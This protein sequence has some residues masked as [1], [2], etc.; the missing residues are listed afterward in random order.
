MM[1]LWR[2]LCCK[3]LGIL[4][5]EYI[6]GIPG[7][8]K[9]FKSVFD[10]HSV[11]IAKTAKKWDEN[12]HFFTNISEFQFDKFPENVAFEFDF[13]VFYSNLSSLYV[14]Y[15]AKMGDIE[16]S[17]QAKIF[18][19]FNA[20]YV[21]DECHNFLDKE[22]KIL[23]WW[24]TYH[25]HFHQNIVFLTQ[26]LGLVKP[27]YK[28]STEFFYSAVPASRRFDLSKLLG[29]SS[30]QYKHFATSRKTK[31]DYVGTLK[32]DFN[33]D[34]YGLYHSG[35]NN[36]PKNIVVK[37]V[38]IAIGF[39]L[40]AVGLIWFIANVLFKRNDPPKDMNSTTS[41]QSINSPAQSS[42][43]VNLS[44]YVLCDR[45]NCSDGSSTQQHIS[46]YSSSILVPGFIDV[47]AYPGVKK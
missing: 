9:T 3:L 28:T 47:R 15:K 30:F 44:D 7:S 24:V 22:D 13:D 6:D 40:L 31:T 41:V 43:A 2:H 21:I 10:L 1:P 19:M 11:F 29:K 12:D 46:Q 37:F 26:N 17:E 39:I 38:L 27:C 14:S 25:R 20:C 18:N 32:Y 4:V 8:G 5:I 36:Q 42:S 33:S 16:L 23:T 34:V 45:F 35:A